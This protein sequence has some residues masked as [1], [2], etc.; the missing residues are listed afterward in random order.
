MIAIIG[1]LI[2]LLLPAVQAAREAARRMQC[3][4]NLKQM[5]L[6]FHNY[7]DAT[8]SLPYGGMPGTLWEPEFTGSNWRHS[9]LPYVELTSVYSEA[10]YNQ[11]SFESGQWG[12][13]V[14][15]NVIYHEL[16]P[17]MY[18]CPSSGNDALLRGASTPL[19]ALYNRDRDYAFMTH[20]YVGVMGAYP[21]PAVPSRAEKCRPYYLGGNVSNSGLLC[22]E[23]CRTLASATDGTSNTLIVVEQSGKYQGRDIRSSYGGGW[24]GSRYTIQTATTA[25]PSYPGLAVMYPTG[26]ITLA[27]AIN[28]Q[29]VPDIDVSNYPNDWGPTIV[30]SSIA[31]SSHTAGINAARADGSVD[32]YSDTLAIHVL[33]SLGCRDD[34]QVVSP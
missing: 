19:G 18:R 12:M 25:F 28:A 33:L 2:A 10:L 30:P 20:D 6:A 34:G 13:P 8:K 32:F 5:G 22:S 1:I 4:N 3:S 27:W 11:S 23:E 15:F 16:I 14:P 21:D 31:N 24:T 7:H 9:L 26:L 29:S 17:T